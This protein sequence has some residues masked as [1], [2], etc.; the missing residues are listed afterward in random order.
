[1]SLRLM[2]FCF[3]LFLATLTPHVVL[4]VCD[5]P[6]VYLE[7]LRCVSTPGPLFCRREGTSYLGTGFKETCSFFA[8][9]QGRIAA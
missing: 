3:S 2:R 9:V 5:V 1:M 7:L 8:G 6:E 4:H